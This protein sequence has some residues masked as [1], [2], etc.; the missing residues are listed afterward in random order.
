MGNTHL[1]DPNRVTYMTLFLKDILKRFPPE[2]I[3][4]FSVVGG[5]GTGKTYLISQMVGSYGVKSSI[6]D[7]YGYWEL[8]FNPLRGLLP[9]A[10]PILLRPK[11]DC[12]ISDY[13]KG[14]QTSMSVRGETGCVL[15][16]NRGSLSELGRHNALLDVI[17]SAK[18]DKTKG[19]FK[20]SVRCNQFSI[21]FS[22]DITDDLI[23]DRHS[24]LEESVDD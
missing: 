10:K 20:V 15:Y 19:R 24:V 3:P 13:V 14:V 17:V 4:S 8:W 6:I 2:T 7:P 5:A 22:T 1:L 16:E 23:Y 12:N 11:D 21:P 9:E 18:R